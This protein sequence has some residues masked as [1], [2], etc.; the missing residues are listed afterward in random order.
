MDFTGRWQATELL[1]P[2]VRLT[3]AFNHAYDEAAGYPNPGRLVSG[4]LDVRF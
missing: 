4:G 3:N 1:A 2:Y